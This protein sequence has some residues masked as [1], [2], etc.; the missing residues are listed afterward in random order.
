MALVR[1]LVLIDGHGHPTASRLT[2]SVQIRV[3]RA[4]HF[5]PSGTATPSQDVCEFTLSRER[6]FSGQ[7][8]GLRAVARGDREFALFH[9]HGIDWFES[10]EDAGHFEETELRSCSVCHDAAGKNSFLS[11]SRDRFSR[12]DGPPPKL[13]ASTPPRETARQIQW[14]EQHGKLSF[15]DRVA[16]RVR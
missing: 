15:A 10:Q 11:Y 14:I 3:Y 5:D 7:A 4:S 9:S 6:L 12:L 13:I 8:G 1:Q 2:E 16:N